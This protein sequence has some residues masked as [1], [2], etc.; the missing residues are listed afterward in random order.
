M[1]GERGALP[2]DRTAGWLPAP[3]RRHRLVATVF[4]FAVLVAYLVVRTR[5]ADPFGG[6]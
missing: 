3:S 2:K 6:P 4:A 5:L 1:R